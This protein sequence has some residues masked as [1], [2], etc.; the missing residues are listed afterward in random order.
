MPED[1][2]ERVPD[3]VAMDRRM[4]ACSLAT[5]AALLGC[6][7]PPAAQAVAKVEPPKAEPPEPPKVE[8]PTVE[9]PKSV[10]VEAVNPVVPPEPKPPIEP[11]TPAEAKSLEP[12]VE[13]KPEP[14]PEPKPKPDPLA[15]AEM[16]PPESEDLLLELVKLH[17]P[18]NLEPAHLKAIRIEIQRQLARSQVL[19]SFPLQ[20][21]DEP[22]SVFSAYR[23]PG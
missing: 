13:L 11:K 19:S 15:E 23:G 9:P 7:T 16:E 4:F 12:K 10:P 2:V 8:A 14:K 6:G 17:Y 22:A 18:R 5:A 3:R 21:S 1:P 20:N